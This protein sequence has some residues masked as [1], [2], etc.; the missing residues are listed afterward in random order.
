LSRPDQDYALWAASASYSLDKADEP[1]YLCLNS[2][3]EKDYLVANH[4]EKKCPANR[5]L[6]QDQW[7]IIFRWNNGNA[8]NVDIID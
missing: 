3:Q 4:L 5:G 6:G 7:R 1:G 2:Y 8:E